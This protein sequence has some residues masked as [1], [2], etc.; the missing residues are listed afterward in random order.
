M[1]VPA[2]RPTRLPM[3]AGMDDPGKWRVLVEAIFPNAQSSES[4]LLALEYCKQRGLDPLKKPVNIV[5]MWN[6][7]LGKYVETVWASINEIEVTAAR[8]GQWAGMDPPQW[9][10]VIPRKFTGRK[11]DRGE[12][13]NVTV[14]VS[15][16]EWCA[17]TVY[18][19][20]SGMR[21]AFTEPV[22]WM[23][24][25][26]RIGGSELPNDMWCKRPRGQ[27]H[28]V[29]KAASL[30]AAFPEEGD[31]AAEE[32]EGAVI[33]APAPPAPPA[34]ADNWKPPD[35]IPDDATDSG[36]SIDGETGEIGPRTLAQGDEEEARE[37]CTRFLTELRKSKTIEDVDKW[38]AAN[39]EISERIK[40]DAPKLH[41]QLKAAIGRHRVELTEP[42][43]E[44]PADDQQHSGTETSETAKAD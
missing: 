3:P 22:Y 7:K 1:N 26:G 29:A 28:K 35:T 24:A 10:P 31:Y 9:G 15:Y 17:V 27:L 36:D 39:L 23:E 13:V 30:R 8:T 14:E 19:V 4:V 40:T 2:L 11:K 34:P 25:Y 42:K 18:R 21:C 44:K 6:S 32:M 41:I 16:P 43:Q 37:W 20:I 38:E 33:D 5:P 12:W